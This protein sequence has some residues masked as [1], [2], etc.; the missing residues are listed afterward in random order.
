A[1]DERRIRGRRPEAVVDDGRLGPAALAAGETV[2]GFGP[3]KRARGDLD[4][5]RVQRDLLRLQHDVVGKVGEPQLAGEACD[6]PQLR[7]RVPQAAESPLRGVLIERCLVSTS[8]RFQFRCMTF[9]G[10]TTTSP[11]WSSN[12][13]GSP[14]ISTVITPSRM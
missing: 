3:R 5:E 11:G 12:G 1:V 13:S 14:S 8:P 9:R 10:N 2:R 6:V 7:H 4:P